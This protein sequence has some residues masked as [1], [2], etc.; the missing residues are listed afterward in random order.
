MDWKT[1]QTSELVQE[2]KQAPEVRNYLRENE[3]NLVHES[4]AEQFRKVFAEQSRTKAEVARAAGISDI[5]L[6][7]I[8]SGNRTPSRDRL[9]CICLGMQ[10]AP[11]TAQRLLQLC[12]YAP[13]YARTE[14]DAIIL[15]GLLH[16]K[17]VQDVNRSLLDCSMK[18]F[19]R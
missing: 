3:A 2:L 11:E 8:L 14:W 4:F 10:V 19:Y 16:G 6:F 7:Q 13:L 12:G 9:L 18:P 15:H 1:K 5:Y 17:S